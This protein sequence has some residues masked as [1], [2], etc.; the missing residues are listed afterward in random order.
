MVQ[1]QPHTI[2]SNCLTVQF[3]VCIQ[4]EVCT[5]FEVRVQFEVWIQFEVSVSMLWWENG[6]YNPP[7]HWMWFC[8][9]DNMNQTVVPTLKWFTVTVRSVTVPIWSV[10]AD[11]S[12]IVLVCAGTRFTGWSGLCPVG[13]PAAKIPQWVTITDTWNGL[14]YIGHANCYESF[15][16]QPAVLLLQ[17]Q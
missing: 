7:S 1:T 12:A 14:S 13:V 6:N 4:F 3:K 15:S 16:P 10:I 11:L 9:H 8:C 17:G 2:D 5:Q